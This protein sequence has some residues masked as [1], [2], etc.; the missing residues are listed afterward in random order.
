[1]CERLHVFVKGCQTTREVTTSSRS[2]L[3]GLGLSVGSRFHPTAWDRLPGTLAMLKYNITGLSMHFLK[4]KKRK[5]MGRLATELPKNSLLRGAKKVVGEVAGDPGPGPVGSPPRFRLVPWGSPSGM[6]TY[7]AVSFGR[8]SDCSRRPCGSTRCSHL[9]PQPLL[10]RDWC[11]NCLPHV[12]GSG[13][14]RAPGR[15]TALFYY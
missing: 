7:I 11:T 12:G 9:E 5:K 1:M 13:S 15:R 4:R 6:T 3:Q 8:R 14:R 10:A 2:S